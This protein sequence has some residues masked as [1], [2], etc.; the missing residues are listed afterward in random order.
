MDSPVANRRSSTVAGTVRAHP[1]QKSRH[2]L[3]TF[4]LPV[5]LPVCRSIRPRFPSA[6]PICSADAPTPSRE[7]GSCAIGTRAPKRI[8]RVAGSRYV[9]EHRCAHGREIAACRYHE[10]ATGGRGEGAKRGSSSGAPPPDRLRRVLK[11]PKDPLMLDPE[12]H[13]PDIELAQPMDS[14]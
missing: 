6:D 3:Y 12:L 1:L 11:A 10:G 5:I 9:S 4:S 13:P 8:R 14:C 7:G 2:I